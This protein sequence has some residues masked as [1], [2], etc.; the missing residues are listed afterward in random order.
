MDYNE[1]QYQKGLDKA[2]KQAKYEDKMKT[3]DEFVKIYSRALTEYLIPR[4][5]KI[6][7]KSHIED[8]AVSNADFAESFYITI[9]NLGI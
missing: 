5:G 1:E 4:L 3:V 7:T 9:S 2:A 6:N 8:I